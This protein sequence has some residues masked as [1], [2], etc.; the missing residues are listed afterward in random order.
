LH[1]ISNELAHKNSEKLPKLSD[2][3]A[4]KTKKRYFL[5]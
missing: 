3:E 2:F 5:A 4:K 1:D